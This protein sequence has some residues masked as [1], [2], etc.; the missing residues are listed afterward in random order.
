MEMTTEVA[1]ILVE[2]VSRPDTI[3]NVSCYVK[4]IRRNWTACE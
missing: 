2:Q 4:V 1:N 3:T